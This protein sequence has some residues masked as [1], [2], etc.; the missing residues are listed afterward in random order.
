MKRQIGIL[1][2]MAILMMGIA[3]AAGEASCVIDQAATTAGTSSGYIRGTTQNISA[4]I[5]YATGEN[6]GENVTFCNVTSS[7]GTIIASQFYGG[8]GSGNA[9]YCNTTIDVTRLSD[10]TSYT[11]TL[12]MYNESNGNLGTC[13]R[14]YIPDNSQPSCTH[15][16]SSKSTYPPKQTWTVTGTNSSSATIQFGSNVASSMTESTAGD[17][18]TF[19]GKIPESTYDITAITNDGLNTTTCTLDSVRIDASSTAQQVGLATAGAAA[20]AKAAGPNNMAIIV[21]F[22]IAALWYVNKKK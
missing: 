5:T 21:I 18:F 2:L 22:G 8:A 14:V 7:A 15:S 12:T 17:T 16:Q 6:T 1:A 4:T 20:G 11:F 19:A 10:E 9:T 13:T 3:Y